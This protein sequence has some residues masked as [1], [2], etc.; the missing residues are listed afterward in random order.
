MNIKAP[1]DGFMYI[2]TSNESMVNVMFDNL[3]VRHTRGRVLEMNHYY[4]YGM[5][6]ERLSFSTPYMVNNRYKYQGKE[7]EREMGLWTMDFGLR[8]YD[9]ATARWSATDPYM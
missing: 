8:Q 4:P 3:R 7:L 2:Y 5:V 9:P 1:T 6:M